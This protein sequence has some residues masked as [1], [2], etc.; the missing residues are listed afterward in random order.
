[1]AKPVTG[2]A[3]AGPRAAAPESSS[4]TGPRGAVMAV[5]SSVA[6]IGPAAAPGATTCAAPL[7][8]GASI[9]AWSNHW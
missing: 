2:S 7:L 1:M 5:A 9:A 6:A 3:E 4:S 8:T